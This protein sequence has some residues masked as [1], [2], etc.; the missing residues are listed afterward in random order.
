[1]G[2]RVTRSPRLGWLLPFGLMVSVFAGAGIMFS[3]VF[4][5]SLLA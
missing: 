5:F 1:M 4:W 3:G 2:W